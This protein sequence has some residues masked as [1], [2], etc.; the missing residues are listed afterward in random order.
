MKS[1]H[2]PRGTFLLKLVKK[3]RLN[4]CRYRMFS[5]W[6]IQYFLI[7][8]IFCALYTIQCCLE[9][10][11]FNISPNEIGIPFRQ[12]SSILPDTWFLLRENYY[13][14]RYTIPSTIQV[15]VIIISVHDCKSMVVTKVIFILTLTMNKHLPYLINDLSGLENQYTTNI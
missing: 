2:S 15:L 11:K 3:I 9:R 4:F 10:Y 5:E 13:I 6:L 7:R 12:S 8:Q 14:V 1:L